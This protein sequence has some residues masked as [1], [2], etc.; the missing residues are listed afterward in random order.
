M[1]EMPR[2]KLRIIGTIDVTKIQNQNK[3][4]SNCIKM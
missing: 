2:K 4:K 3:D 1:E